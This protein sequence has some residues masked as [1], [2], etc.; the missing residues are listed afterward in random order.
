MK[1]AFIFIFLIPFVQLSFGDIKVQWH[2][3]F[4]GSNSEWVYSIQQTKEGGYIIA[5]ST[6]SNDG[7]VHGCHNC[8]FLKSDAWILKLDSIGNIVW[9]KVLGGSGRD[10]AASIQQTSDGGYVVVGTTQSNDGDVSGN[11]GKSDMWIIKL[12]SKGNIVWQ[13]VLG[14]SNG[15]WG[16][17]IQ[18]T[19][20]GGYIAL[21]ETWSNDG[22][23]RGK[24][25]KSDLWVVKLD[26]NGNIQWQKTL[27]G[28]DEEWAASIQ[29]TSD[30]GYIVVGTTQSNDGDVSGYHG[31]VTPMGGD[32][33][34]VKLDR[35]G[36]VQWQRTLGGSNDDK[37]L[38]IQQTSDGGYI[39]AGWTFSSDGDVPG[40][41]GYGPY[42]WIV[43][44]DRFGNIRWRS[45]LGGKEEDVIRS[46]RET[47][48]GGYIAVGYTESYC[49]HAS[50][51]YV[52]PDFW[53]VR[54][55]YYG[56]VLWYAA[57]GGSK[58][59]EAYAVQPTSDGGFIIAGI[60]ESNDGDV[61]GNHGNSDI[62]IIKL[63][64]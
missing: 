32:Y 50:G 13:K 6:A 43:K 25:G 23:V 48:D 46:I 34:V 64:Y 51:Y 5:G 63:G 57:I 22:D 59:D 49:R 20:D 17:S 7:D 55:N 26:S 40:N 29:Q 35:R 52:K 39:V 18:Q 62:W 19:K 44:L 11:H 58:T 27:G 3:V 31:N 12:D 8:S 60:T 21:G 10:E 16:T 47:Q 4:G 14:G 53:I 15:D 28:S 33:W 54:L 45:L 30:G 36:N 42:A 38:S 24:H 56:T 37:A 41:A 2:K 1:K 61:Y 9:Q